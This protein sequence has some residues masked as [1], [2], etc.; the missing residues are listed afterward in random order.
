ME[1]L[2]PSVLP[3]PFVCKSDRHDSGCGLFSNQFKQTNPPLRVQLPA[4]ALLSEQG[5]VLTGPAAVRKPWHK[6]SWYKGRKRLT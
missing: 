4:P 5:G 3:V 6:D 1:S 2:Y